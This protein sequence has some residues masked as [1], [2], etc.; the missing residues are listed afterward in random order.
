MFDTIT[1]FIDEY[2]QYLQKDDQDIE[3]LILCLKRVHD[4]MQNNNRFIKIAETMHEWIDNWIQRYGHVIVSVCMEMIF[5]ET[6]FRV[7]LHEYDGMRTYHKS[8]IMIIL[9]IITLFE[10]MKELEDHDEIEIKINTYIGYIKI[11]FD[12]IKQIRMKKKI[13]EDL[14][15]EISS[16]MMI[17]CDSDMEEIYCDDMILMSYIGLKNKGYDIN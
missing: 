11:C 13:D 9:N 2:V 1:S 15:D 3:Q 12:D 4:E 5:G 6:F 7:L 16:I 8:L 14:D 17:L 10:T